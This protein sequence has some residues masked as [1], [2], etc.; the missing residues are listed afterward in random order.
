MSLLDG[1]EHVVRQDESLAP[2]TRLNIG[3]NAEY[4]AEPTNRDELIQLVKRF[5]ENDQPIRLIGSGSN[6]LVSD[7]GVSG[8]VIHLGA[9]EF[10]SINV[11]E[12]G[13]IA[14]GGARL[15]HFVSM[16]AREGFA[17]PERLVG[18]PGTIGGA[19]HNNTGAHG[20]DIGTWV[21]RAEV[22]TRAGEVAERDAESMAFSYRQSSLSELVILSAEFEFE[23]GD[24][25]ELS[26]AMQKLWIVRRASHV[27]V[28]QHAAYM[29]EDSGSESASTLIERAGVTGTKVG[30]VSLFDAD[31]NFFVCEPGATSDE[32]KQMIRTV[33]Q[34]VQDKL[35]IDLKTAIQIW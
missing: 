1:F 16:A 33:Q 20:V 5:S 25:N 24:V 29:F 4:F 28:D 31:P 21:K 30:K 35:E 11:T 26:K 2:F 10:G 19:L 23:K 27:S 22:L 9:A 32:V 6:L 34:Q 8:L 15:S 12:R 18:L 7:E 17:G 13:L 14:G 3:G